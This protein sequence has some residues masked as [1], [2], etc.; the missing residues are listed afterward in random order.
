MVAS[1]RL[2]E[3]TGRHEDR[4]MAFRTPL[5][6]NYERYL[7]DYRGQASRAP[8][9]SRCFVPTVTKAQSDRNSAAERSLHRRQR[10]SPNVSFSIGWSTNTGMP[11]SRSRISAEPPNRSAHDPG[12]HRR[13]R[14]RVKIYDIEQ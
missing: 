11:T 4:P 6:K 14:T 8:G 7:A 5:P 1:Y 3:E 13:R 2:H 9:A 12:P 10:N